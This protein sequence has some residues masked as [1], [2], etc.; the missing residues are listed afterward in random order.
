MTDESKTQKAKVEELELNRETI[1]EL[2]EREAEQSRGG[3]RWRTERCQRC[4]DPEIT[5][6]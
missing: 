2:T 4:T 5:C 1:Q 6:I 3:A